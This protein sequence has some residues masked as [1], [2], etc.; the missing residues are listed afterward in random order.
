MADS[1]AAPVELTPKTGPK[2]N[3]RKSTVKLL[4]FLLALA[5]LGA[6]NALVFRQITH[7][8]ATPAPEVFPSDEIIINDQPVGN[9]IL[10]ERLV[11]PEDGFLVIVPKDK[12]PI[13]PLGFSSYIPA[14][15]YEDFYVRFIVHRWLALKGEGNQITAKL[16]ADN[17]NKVFGSEDRVILSEEGLPIQKTL[18]LAVKEIPALSCSN[19]FSEDFSKTLDKERWVFSL[20]NRT[21]EGA[22]IQQI[23]EL[24][25]V[26]LFT[27]SKF[28]GDFEANVDILSFQAQKENTE[29]SSFV[30]L[31]AFNE[32]GGILYVRWTKDQKGSY[33]NYGFRFNGGG[34]EGEDFN[35]KADSSPRFKVVREGSRAT[36]S[37]DL[38]G[39]YQ[40]LWE[41]AI[42]SESAYLGLVSSNMI[43]RQPHQVSVELDNFSLSCLQEGQQEEEIF[44]VTQP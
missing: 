19:G 1:P 12:Y 33:L 15:T 11:L 44:E 34:H 42:S 41:T 28:G 20:G 22:L 18:T 25:D 26:Y 2:P 4:T 21:Q 35:L 43:G 13:S 10:V 23:D 29:R 7:L 24:G 14:G 36:I 16:Y 5:L 40:E 3:P 31:T 38:G 8:R 30:E 6:G 39:G 17:G 9:L 37:A 27:K 32:E